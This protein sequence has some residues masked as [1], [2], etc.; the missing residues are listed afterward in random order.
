MNLQEEKAREKLSRA[1]LQFRYLYHYGRHVHCAQQ[2]E[3]CSLRPGDVMMLFS[4]RGEQ[5]RHG[6]VTATM[7]SRDIGIKTPSVNTVLSTLEEKGLI[8]RKTDPSDRRFVLINLSE[9]GE[10]QVNKFDEAFKTRINGLVEYLGAEKSDQLTE[11]MN[12]VYEYLR[13][14]S[15]STSE[16]GRQQ[17]PLNH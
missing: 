1:F 12:E 5:K 13:Q 14:K 17:G 6:G 10:K 15:D 8:C 2:R 16:Q 3:E 9:E 7:L 11:L 4:I